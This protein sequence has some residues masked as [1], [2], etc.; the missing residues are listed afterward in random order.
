MTSE[1]EKKRNKVYIYG[2]TGHVTIC[3]DS[4]MG[5]M[6][7]LTPSNTPSKETYLQGILPVQLKCHFY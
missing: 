6:T 5:G 1:E 7:M 2:V 3:A 4:S